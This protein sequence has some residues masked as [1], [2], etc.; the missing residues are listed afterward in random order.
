M[1]ESDVGYIISEALKTVLIA[2]AP[3]LGIALSIGIFVAFFQALTQ[4]QEMTLTF[5]PKIIGIM[6]AV[7]FFLP[8]IYRTLAAFSEVIFDIIISGSV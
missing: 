1:N 8:F 5:V 4:I 2:S 3:V 7:I 6:I